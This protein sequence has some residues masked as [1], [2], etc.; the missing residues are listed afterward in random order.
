MPWADSFRCMVMCS[1][2]NR[3]AGL[4]FWRNRRSLYHNSVRVEN[5]P[6]RNF[7]QDNGVTWKFSS[8]HV[9]HM[10]DARKSTEG[11]SRKICDPLLHCFNDI[12][13]ELVVEI[14][15]VVSARPFIP[16][17]YEPA[18]PFLLSPSTVL[19]QKTRSFFF[20]IPH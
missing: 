14:C 19:T 16:V 8:H 2:S 9:S 4:F 6:V 13:R 11:A 1:N 5:R 17:Y 18:N 10:D 7:L 12:T 20:K 15:A 3:F